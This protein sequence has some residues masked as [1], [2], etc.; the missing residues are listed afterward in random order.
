MSGECLGTNVEELHVQR[1]HTLA[2][3]ISVGSDWRR[4][5]LAGW[6]TAGQAAKVEVDPKR[7]LFASY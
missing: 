4:A 5:A 7:A 3:V 2:F 6:M 1:T